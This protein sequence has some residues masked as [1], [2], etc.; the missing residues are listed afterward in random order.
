[1]VKSK[2]RFMISV[3]L[4]NYKR[5]HI[6]RGRLKLKKKYQELGNSSKL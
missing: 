1:M 5:K 4:F 3:P 6:F 2:P